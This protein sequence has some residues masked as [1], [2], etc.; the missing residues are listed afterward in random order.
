MKA[1]KSSYCFW[2]PIGKL[3]W[4]TG[5]H[6]STEQRWLPDNKLIQTENSGGEDDA[7]LFNDEDPPAL[8]CT[9]GTHPDPS[10]WNMLQENCSCVWIWPGAYDFN[11][12]TEPELG[13]KENQ[14]QPI[15]TY[16]SCLKTNKEQLNAGWKHLPGL[17]F[18]HTHK[19][20]KETNIVHSICVFYFLPC[21]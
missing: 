9:P 7:L 12:L 2:L 6:P 3:H 16:L 15:F 13:T 8:G 21:Q 10:W 1:N 11:L 4:R 14:L 18:I 5:V 19:K 17:Y 20:E